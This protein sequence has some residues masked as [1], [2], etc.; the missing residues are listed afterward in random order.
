MSNSKR[1]SKLLI[2]S[3]WASHSKLNISSSYNYLKI[4]GNLNFKTLALLEP[5]EIELE[6]FASKLKNS[7]FCSFV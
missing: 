6:K 5:L 7:K 2:T 3:V 1:V 4:L